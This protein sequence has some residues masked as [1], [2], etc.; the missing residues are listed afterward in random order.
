MMGTEKQSSMTF[1]MPADLHGAF[2]AACKGRDRTAAQEL[3]AFMRDYVER[4]AQ[5]RLPLVSDAAK[6][7]AKR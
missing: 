4:N 1:R 2:V 6:P 3:R 5:G 7:G